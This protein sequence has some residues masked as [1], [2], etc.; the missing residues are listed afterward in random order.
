M[1]DVCDRSLAT[2]YRHFFY[3]GH[4]GV[5]ERLAER[6]QK[7]FPGLIVAGTCSPPF[8]PL[9]AEEDEEIVQRIN[10]AKPDLVWVGLSTPR[11]EQLDGHRRRDGCSAVGSNCSFVWRTSRDGCGGGTW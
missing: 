11:Q 5:P 3:G 7:R 10:D 1:L 4:D 8:R 9:S 2:G 6:L